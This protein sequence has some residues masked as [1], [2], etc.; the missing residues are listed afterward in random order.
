MR[1]SGASVHDAVREIITHNRSLYDCVKMGIANYTALA[2]RIRPAVERQTGAPA[3]PNTI[4]VAIKRYA[5]SFG[6]RAAAAGEPPGGSLR[7]ARLSLTDGVVG[8]TVAARDLDGDPLEAIARL[9]GAA[10]GGYEFFG[11]SGSF[12]LIMEDAD[13][14]RGVLE[15]AGGRGR[16][17]GGLAKITITVPGGHTHSDIVSYVAELLHGG[18]IELVNAFF[19]HDAVTVILDERDAAR[20]YDLLRSQS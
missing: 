5:D 12:V 7:D 17:S 3:N 19:G 2:E 18:G 14:A 1:A 20:A 15:G 9:A 10:G 6:G 11:V 13:G 8:V 4:V 16:L